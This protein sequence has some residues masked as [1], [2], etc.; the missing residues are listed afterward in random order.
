MK[1]HLLFDISDSSTTNPVDSADIY[2]Q[3]LIKGGSKETFTPLLDVKDKARIRKAGLGDVLQADGCT[4][5]DQG[6]GTLSEKLVSAT[7]IKVNFEICQ[8]TLETSFVSHSMASGA[9]KAD[10]LP[11]DFRNYLTDEL[12]KKM[13]ADFEQLVWQGDATGSTYPVPLADGLLI[14]FAADGDVIDVSATTVDSTNV[15][16]ELNRVYDAIPQAILFSPDLK[17][18]VSTNIMQAYR[19]A[20]AAASSEAYYDL[21]IA[22]PMFLGIPM[23]LAQGLP[24][25]RMVA[26]ESTNLFLISDLMSDFED[27][28]ILP[29]LDVTGDDVVRIVGRLQ[30]AVSYAYGN[31]IVMYA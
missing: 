25:N 19:Q 27:I 24:A 5:N 7:P 18:Y 21:K 20:V 15:I 28:R 23:V 11:A 29:Q 1:K 10:F 4:F 16:A 26:A 8:S 3:A 17:M 30:F 31:E 6:A 22:A 9:N 2:A 13:S 14:Q 12:S